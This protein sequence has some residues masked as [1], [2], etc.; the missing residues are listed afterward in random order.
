MSPKRISSHARVKREILQEYSPLWKNNHMLVWE[1]FF[2][3]VFA[4]ENNPIRSLEISNFQY[5]FMETFFTIKT[6][7]DLKLQDQVIICANTKSG[8]G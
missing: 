8:R 2:L 6:Y 1:F 4:P 3:L 5:L 7:E